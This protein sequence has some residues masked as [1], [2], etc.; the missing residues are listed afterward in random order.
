MSGTETDL[1]ARDVGLAR[2]IPKST[3][4]LCGHR[5]SASSMYLAEQ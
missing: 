3:E 1:C 5:F 2:P 4:A